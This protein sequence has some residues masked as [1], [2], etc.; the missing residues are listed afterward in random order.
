MRESSP[1][2]VWSPVSKTGATTDGDSFTVTKN[3]LLLAIALAA[4][5][6]VWQHAALFGIQGS[7]WAHTPYLLV[8]VLL[9][10]PV[11]AVAVG[12]VSAVGHRVNLRRGSNPALSTWEPVARAA[13]I[14]IV[15]TVLYIPLAIAQAVAHSAIAPPTG[16]HHG[17]TGLPATDLSGLLG[18]DHP[19]RE[20][21]RAASSHG[22]S[23][24]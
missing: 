20:Q 3:N 21:A 5:T 16:H 11:A 10:F 22:R 8:D 9:A 4:G 19:I 17:A 14:T 18:S 2:P 7:L 23:S 13:A 15:L 6:V 1:V 12:L 24:R